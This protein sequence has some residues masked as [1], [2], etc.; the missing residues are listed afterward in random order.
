MISEIPWIALIAAL[1]VLLA[2]FVAVKGLRMPSSFKENQK[3][4]VELRR[5]N[6]IDRENS[7]K[8]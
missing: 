7:D 2:L 3:K 8:K 6:A 1:A 4:R 5:K